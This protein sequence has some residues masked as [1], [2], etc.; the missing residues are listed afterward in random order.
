MRLITSNTSC[1]HGTLP[2]DTT[3]AYFCIC[4]PGWVFERIQFHDDTCTQPAELTS[5]YFIGVAAVTGFCALLLFREI[6]IRKRHGREI[7]LWAFITMLLN[8]AWG[9]CIS[10][11]AGWYIGASICFSLLLS[12]ASLFIYRTMMIVL[13][14]FVNDEGMMIIRSQGRRCVGAS[15]IIFTILGIAQAATSRNPDPDGF[16]ITIYLILEISAIISVIFCYDIFQVL[17][18]NLK[19]PEKTPRVKILKRDIFVQ[20]FLSTVGFFL[21]PPIHAGIGVLNWN[22]VALS[23]FYMLNMVGFTFTTVIF[24]HRE[25]RRLSQVSVNEAVPFSSIVV[26]MPGMGV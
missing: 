25:G 22:G 8:S 9:F 17:N 12:C 26:T 2:P 10:F 1:G 15:L 5:K 6:F 7:A 4:E 24:L 21:V 13:E 18:N 11:E 19:D 20:T 3:S 16:H 23:F 14:P